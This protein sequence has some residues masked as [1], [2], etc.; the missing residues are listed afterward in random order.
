M[1]THLK[2]IVYL[3]QL[4]NTVKH[5]VEHHQLGH[6]QQDT[7]V[8]LVLMPKL[9]GLVI[10]YVTLDMYVLRVPMMMAKNVLKDFTAP[11]K[12]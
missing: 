7:S 2:M 9:L 1:F 8:Q 10:R 5:Q 4:V 6:V 11:E 3:V 12:E